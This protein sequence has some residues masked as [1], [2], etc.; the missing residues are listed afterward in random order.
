MSL[1]YYKYGQ[2]EQVTVRNHNKSTALERSVLKYWWGGGLKPVL[3]DPDH[4]LSFFKSENG[5]F[6]G[7]PLASYLSSIA[8]AGIAGHETHVAVKY[9][10]SWKGCVCVCIISLFLK[11]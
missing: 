11:R 10:C 9:D 8:M 2:Q 5:I 6:A 1:T 7:E 3:R 4:A